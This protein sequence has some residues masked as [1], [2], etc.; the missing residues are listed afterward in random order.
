MQSLG[1]FL[2]I[3]G[4]A[5][6]L[7]GVFLWAGGRFFPMLG[8]LPG[9]IVISRKNLTIFLPFTTMIIISLVLTVVANLLS[10]WIK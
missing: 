8:K 3:T 5:I 6:T 4:T 1:K 7:A 2:V 10:K 9:D